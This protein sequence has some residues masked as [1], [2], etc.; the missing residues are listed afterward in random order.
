MA[1]SAG[2]FLIADTAREFRNQRELAEKAAAQL[3]DE[4]FFRTSGAEAN[5]VAVIMKHVGGNLR[6]RWTDFL[7][8]DG[9]KEDRNRDGEFEI[10]ETRDEIF[11]I[12]NM[13]FDTLDRTLSSLTPEDL[14]QTITI[15]QEP[16]VVIRAMNRSLAHTAHHVGQ[17]VLLAKQWRAGEWQTLSIPRARRT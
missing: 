14:L 13:G 2:A 4:E 10:A 6:S 9:E 1:E 12:W 8:T 3:D 16:L 11:N 7:T 17:I 5:S 15:R